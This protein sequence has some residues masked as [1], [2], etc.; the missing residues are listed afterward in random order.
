MEAVGAEVRMADK[1][2]AFLREYCT[3]CHDLQK[4]KG[5]LRLD[6]IS[7]ALDSVENADRWQKILNQ[8]NAGE[9]PPEEAVQPQ[10][11]AK[12]EFLDAL[13]HVLV[14]ARRS[15]SD[16]GGKITM[17]RLNRREY[18]NTLRDLLGVEI[19]VRELP[20][21]GGAGNFDTV[22]S[23]L[24]I[25]SD[26]IEQYLSL[27]RQALE[28]HFARNPAAVA[29]HAGARGL[30]AR[31]ETELLANREMTGLVG[32]LSQEHDRYLQWVAAVDAE[33]LRTD[34][35]ALFGMLRMEPQVRAN[36]ELFYVHWQKHRD[37][38]SP[39]QFGYQ[40]ADLARFFGKTQFDRL[41]RY[42]S[43]Y[44]AMPRRDTGSYLMSYNGH[45][46]EKIPV[47]ARWP[48]GTYTLRIRLAA[49]DDAPAERRFVQIGQHGENITI[50]SLIGT[51]QVTGTLDAPQIL[52]VQVN[53]ASAGKREFVIREKQPGDRAAQGA[54]W[55]DAYAKTGTGPR[56]SIWI[57]YV[58]VEGP[59]Q[60][61]PAPLKKR[62]EPEI[63]ANRRIA[64][65]HGRLEKRFENFKQWAAALDAFADRPENLAATAKLPREF[66]GWRRPVAYYRAV[67]ALPDAPSAKAFG[68]SDL[69]SAVFD[70][71]DTF[72][73]DYPYL[74]D[75]LNLPRRDSGAYLTMFKANPKELI[76]AEAGWPAG[77]YVLRVRAAAV[78][79][80]KPE[81]RFLE[82]GHPDPGVRSGPMDDSGTMSVLKSVQVN[83]TMERPQ[84]LEI[85]VDLGVSGPRDFVLREK[86]P[87][88]VEAAGEIWREHIAREKTGPKP[89]L[90]ID[91]IELEGPMVD[92]GGRHSVDPLLPRPASDGDERAQAR[93]AIEGFAVRAFRDK[94][95]SG[96]YIDR[97]VALYD[98]RRAVGEPFDV[99]IREPLSVVLASPGFLYLAEPGQE[100]KSRALTP[101]ELATRLAY[102]LWSG[103]P[104]AG[105][106]ALARSGRLSDPV[107]LEA[108]VDRLIASEKAD[109]FVSGFVHQWLGMERLDFFQFDTKQFRDFDESAKAAARRE[110]YETFAHLLRHGGSLSKLLRSDTVHI[111]GLLANY[112]GIEG[113]QGDEFREVLLAPDSPRGGLLGMAAILA[114]GSNGERTSPVERGA[115]V[116][117]KLLHAP[118]PP[119]PPNV[120]Q[121]S[122]LE[123]QLLTTRE[124]LLAHQEQPQCMQCHRKIDPIGFGLENFN[125]AGKWRTEETFD[126]RGVGRKTWVI[127]AG[128][129]LHN[130][131]AFA[132]YFELRDLLAGKSEDFSRGFTEAL[133]EYALGRPYGFTDRAL[134]DAIV[135]KAQSNGYLLREF[136]LALVKSGEFG[137]K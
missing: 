73:N 35:V 111:N 71:A 123:N 57:D 137:R 18:R 58:E 83:G 6:D 33:A 48:A 117:R 80:S 112:Y 101:A 55:H 89:A 90:W 62:L 115:W 52:E 75:Y 109:E 69:S 116:L 64:D 32:R 29:G 10:R 31:T 63:E 7:F 98:A 4:Q 65:L 88:S 25:S 93:A 102:F 110:V 114:M 11:A 108:Q 125:A 70:G 86:R 61:H 36:A 56:P 53:V 16:S 85:P 51:H 41:F 37:N 15:L 22:G 27:G 77:R 13:S 135:A 42:Y 20:P 105:L 21:D 103:P 5:K 99:A 38:P 19:N 26:Q 24:F 30:L 92:R 9:M 134:A 136:V 120:P 46:F 119:A 49:L 118:P 97:L 94:R 47:D 45:E 133:I 129:S 60:A 28:E 95:P 82:V 68:F 39:K 8:I 59:V 127:H 23:S 2:R 87:N 131:P 1:H 126:K 43:D 34:N 78:E 130:G 113:V 96:E 12:A 124:R 121:I 76:S 66:N 104:D 84:V 79:G 106:L 14:E 72:H 107:V 91:W 3:E 40:D 74:S 67:G 122:R 54:M 44:L 100:G 17:R 128:G 81:R 132:D 50:F